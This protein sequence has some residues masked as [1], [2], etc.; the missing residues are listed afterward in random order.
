MFRLSFALLGRNFEV[1]GHISSST[2]HQI[3]PEKPDNQTMAFPLWLSKWMNQNLSLDFERYWSMSAQD[4]FLVDQFC[5]Y[6]LDGISDWKLKKRIKFSWLS[7][8]W[9]GSQNHSCGA[10]SR[11]ILGI[12]RSQFKW[13]LLINPVSLF[14][15]QK[16]Y[17]YFFS[18][19]MQ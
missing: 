3:K 19:T 5:R 12:Q 6:C 18:C 16:T 11:N 9:I 2:G 17:T 8:Q 14:V 10:C 4:S 7:R 13:L 1:F 15:E